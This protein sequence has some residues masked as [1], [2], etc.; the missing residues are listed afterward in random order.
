MKRITNGVLIEMKE[1]ALKL[2]IPEAGIIRVRKQPVPQPDGEE[3]ILTG[4]LPEYSG[5][6]VQQ[7]PDSVIVETGLIRAVY[8]SSDETLCFC[9]QATGAELLREKAV[10]FVRTSAENGWTG[11]VEQVFCSPE[12]ELIGGMGQQAD[13]AVN[14]KGR[15]VHLNQF[16][17][18]SAVPVFV[19]TKGYGVLWN[20]CSL[21]ELNR[22]RTPLPLEFNP[23]TKTSSAVFTPAQTGEYVWILEKL[24]KN[25]G[26]EDMTLKIGDTMVIER[27]TSW[28]ANFYTGTA[29]L[30]AGKEYPVLLNACAALSYQ[31][32]S[33]REET[34]VWSEVGSGVDY[35]FLYGP[36]AAGVVRA[37]RRLTGDAPL[38]PKWAYGYWQSKECYRTGQ[39]VLDV[40]AEHR[41]RGHP[42]DAIV[43]D[44][45][46]W[47][48]FG[49]NALEFSP[50][51]AE[52]IEEVI[53][54]LHSQDIHFMVSVWPNF[55]EGSK[56]PAYE[57]FR[58]RGFL[59]DD[60]ALK[61]I[62]NYT[63]A[64][65]GFRKNYYD[66]WNPEARDALWRRMEEGLFRKGVD[67]WWLDGTEPN[68]WSIQGAYHMYDTCRGPAA[69]WLNAYT[70]AHS[71]G[72][73]E[74][75]RQSDAQKRV[76][77]LSRTGF[78]GIQKY[79]TAVWSG[80]T[81]YSWQTFRRQI[82]DGL[83]YTLSGLPYWTSDIGGVMGGGCDSP[84]YRELYVRW[85]QFGAFCPIFRA[86][87]TKNPREVWQFGEEV[88][89][90]LHRYLM[91]RYRLLPYIYSLA[92]QI[93]RYQGTMMRSLWMDFRADRRTWKIA[94]Q[95]LFGPSLMVCPVT[96]PGA[97]SREV[98][99]PAGCGWYDFWTNLWHEGGASVT[100]DAP[101]ETL[102]LFVKAGSILLT[103]PETL[104]TCA[105]NPVEIR[106]YSGG[107]AEF[108]W[109][110][111]GGDGYAYETGGYAE[112]L[113]S[114]R[115]QERTL[116]LNAQQGS[117]RMEGQLASVTV[118]NPDGSV[119]RTG[120]FS[121][122]GNKR[123]FSFRTDN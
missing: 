91:L 22:K 110:R 48:D 38:F 35:C 89:R 33:Q 55:G 57:E 29:W 45:Q 34:S 104:H 121:A 101:L 9:E 102:P 61:G 68:L 118:I 28:H 60:A 107:D 53:R 5:W 13:G 11:S 112:V 117:F 85:F 83:Q 41:R 37:Y 26:Y 111:D 23:C 115:E 103:G 97:S 70:L 59:M 4:A 50:D 32:P 12:D 79:A 67:A 75:Q 84:E 87:G 98:Y 62:G 77:I 65:Q 116:T 43:Q 114:W 74:H 17:T 113:L 105:E 6:T 8:T 92:W 93:T 119:Q 19:S 56:S 88:E 106:V 81:W 58:Q 15:F 31:T 94:D 46:Y 25:L 86:H 69:R 36:E 96:E 99:L 40:A 100:A 109:Y 3:L 73:Y 82:A 42:I 95:Y 51:Y 72:I 2:T 21:T 120:P 16:N 64:L 20:N 27:G 108:A 63:A 10:H 78:A 39:E 76:F 52:N 66:A 71:R 54:A 30:E 14:Y 1:G 47:G 49:W 123:I 90:I 80:D 122:D 44:W 18:I 24:N 7:T